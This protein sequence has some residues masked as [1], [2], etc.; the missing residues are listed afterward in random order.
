MRERR[1]TDVLRGMP[2]GVLDRATVRLLRDMEETE[3]Q[4]LAVLPAAQR[5][6]VL[7]GMLA[8][9]DDCHRLALSHRA[10]C[11]AF[12]E[13]FLAGLTERLGDSLD[14]GDLSVALQAGDGEAFLAEVL[15]G[16]LVP[17]DAGEV[18]LAVSDVAPAMSEVDRDWAAVQSGLLGGWIEPAWNWPPLVPLVDGDDLSDGAAVAVDPLAF[19]ALSEPLGALRDATMA[20]E[21][22]LRALPAAAGGQ[23]D[24]LLAADEAEVARLVETFP[25]ARQSL[26]HRLV[27]LTVLAPD[28]AQGLRRILV[29]SECVAALCSALGA[30]S[31][32]IAAV[33][34]AVQARVASHIPQ[35]DPLPPVRTRFY[36]TD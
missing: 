2:P 27:H 31:L 1:L 22:A 30:T 28:E 29:W 7:A 9:R 10:A 21:V 34:A 15:A 3:R 6:A 36:A 11:G 13:A 14:L 4:V 19:E 32:A 17:T 12:R 23:P 24:W 26:A 25:P 16:G 5:S 8:L 18:M 33:N 35:P 20:V